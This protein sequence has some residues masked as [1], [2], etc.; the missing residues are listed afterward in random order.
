MTFLNIVID[1]STRKEKKKKEKTFDRLSTWTGQMLRVAT[2]NG[3]H[4]ANSSA[5]RNARMCRRG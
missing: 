3:V 5:A 2:L 1:R 4:R